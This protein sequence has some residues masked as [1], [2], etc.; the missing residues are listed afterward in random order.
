MLNPQ[1]GCGYKHRGYYIEGGPL[2][3][4][5]GLEPV[6]LC[7]GDLLDGGEAILCRIP[8]RKS[9]QFFVW[10]TFRFGSVEYLGTDEM[11]PVGRKHIDEIVR[12]GTKF[13]GIIDH[14][15]SK[16]YSPISFIK[17]LKELGPSRRV[18]RDMALLVRQLMEAGVGPV[19]IFFSHSQ[20]PLFKSVRAYHKALM[21]AQELFS[22]VPDRKLHTAAAYEREGWGMNRR[23]WG[24]ISEVHPA[25]SYYLLELD[26]ACR[27]TDERFT[28]ARDFLRK[29]VVYAEQLFCCSWISQVSF[30]TDDG[31]VPAA[32]NG[33]TILDLR[34]QDNG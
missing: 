22:I 6:T 8:P 18:S 1:R 24:G 4:G 27:T 2:V 17:E 33:L 21:M 13:V 16:H 31:T 29:H 5:G 25:A 20:V 3:A 28:K 15:G 19:P 7:T 9:L 11:T 26:A 30:A 10:D 32:A 12:K 23:M 14:V 34:E